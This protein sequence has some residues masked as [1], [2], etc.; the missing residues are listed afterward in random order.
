NDLISVL[1]PFSKKGVFYRYNDVN[2][3]LNTAIKA[4]KAQ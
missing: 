2:K 4:V 1:F 3:M